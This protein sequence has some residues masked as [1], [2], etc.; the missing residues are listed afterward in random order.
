MLSEY[1]LSKASSQCIYLQHDNPVCTV[2]RK[3][4]NHFTGF[5]KLIYKQQF[6]SCKQLDTIVSLDSSVSNEKCYH[7]TNSD[8][9]SVLRPS[10]LHNFIDAVKSKNRFIVAGDIFNKSHINRL[11]Y[12]VKNELYI[13]CKLK[14]SAFPSVEAMDAMN[15]LLTD[16][17]GKH[18]KVDIL[19][20]EDDAIITN[21]IVGVVNI[22]SPYL[23]KPNY[24][25]NAIEAG[26]LSDNIT[27]YVGL[28]GEKSWVIK[29]DLD[30]LTMAMFS[31]SDRRV[32]WSDNIAITKQFKDGIVSK[33]VNY[34]NKIIHA[35]DISLTYLDK[36][37]IFSEYDLF[38]LVKDL[39][40]DKL[41]HFED[42]GR[43]NNVHTKCTTHHYRLSIRNPHPEHISSSDI[44]N[45]MDNI[46]DSI[47]TKFAV[48]CF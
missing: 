7:I 38:A 44:S 3:I 11:E 45:L 5:D 42:A 30:I 37:K 48:S 12:P 20:G 27:N 17:V 18:C 25:F 16:V 2:R 28:H 9:S 29:V 36:S 47:K 8:S 26:R 4:C 41:E 15:A 32:L 31:I 23:N 46:K 39:C 6:I 34:D 21:K 43:F 24:A 10:L 1:I 19:D 33:Y 14:H 35:R 13:Y 22:K 40:G